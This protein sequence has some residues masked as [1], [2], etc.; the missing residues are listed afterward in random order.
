M[1]STASTFSVRPDEVRLRDPLDRG[2][3]PPGARRRSP[4]GR[5]FGV[6][7]RPDSYRNI[8]YLLLG[9]PLG[10]VWFT[11]LVTGV[12]TAAGMLA[13]ALI[14]VPMLVVMWYL[15]RAFANVERAAANRLL[16]EQVPYAPIASAHRGN[17]WVRL[18]AMSREQDRWRE[19]GY[20]MARFPAGV[21]TFTAAVAALWTPLMVAWAPIHARIEDHPFGDWAL[22][23]RM[24]DAALSPWAWFLVPLGLL[25]VVVAFHVLNG[26]ARACGRWTTSWLGAGAR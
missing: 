25:L 22:S 12:S 16:Q 20:L 11:A 26:L 18:R 6:V 21:A 19:A 14:G 15:T 9:L 7:T 10:T 4:L 23:S 17:P 3:P 8:A 5:F 13:V 2:E 24:E 1:A